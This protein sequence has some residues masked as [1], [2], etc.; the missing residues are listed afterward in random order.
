MDGA[1]FLDV[2]LCQ[3]SAILKNLP[4]KEEDLL[5]RG[6]ALLSSGLM[7]VTGG[8]EGMLED[9]AGVITQRESALVG[10]C[11]PALG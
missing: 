2:V 5:V 11:L 8:A 3:G 7:P 4:G 6:N 1:P 10:D 9:Q